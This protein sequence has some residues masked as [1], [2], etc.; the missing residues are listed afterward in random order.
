MIDA[1][2]RMQDFRKSFRY[3]VI[4]KIEVS[5]DGN[6]QAS[7]SVI[8][9]SRDG[10]SFQT[11]TSLSVGDRYLVSIDGFGSFDATIVRAFSS[12]LFA[13]QFDVNEQRKRRIDTA[14]SD[15]LGVDANRQEEAAKGAK[16]ASSLTSE[17]AKA[18][19]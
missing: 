3:R 9:I 4:A 17:T 5:K 12:N 14:I 19:A 15:L 7:G 6:R 18:N 11:Y 10:V 13:A 1:K 16:P 8:D 2:S